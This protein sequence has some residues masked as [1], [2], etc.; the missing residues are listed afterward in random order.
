VEVL[1]FAPATS[2]GLFPSLTASAAVLNALVQIMSKREAE[3][4]TAAALRQQ[5]AYLRLV[6]ERERQ[7]ASLRE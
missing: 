5:R 7:A 2:T 6:E 4:Q 1:L 3:A